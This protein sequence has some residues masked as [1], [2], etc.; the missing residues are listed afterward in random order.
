MTLSELP[1]DLNQTLKS[2]FSLAY[3]VKF[4][5]ECLAMSGP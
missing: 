5:H 3:M 2:I 1:F 4:V